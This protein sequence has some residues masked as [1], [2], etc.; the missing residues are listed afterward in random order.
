MGRGDAALVCLVLF[1]GGLS[2]PAVGQS[3]SDLTRE[4][5]REFLLTAEIISGRQSGEGLT[6]PWRLTLSDGTFTHDASYS[7]VD[8]RRSVMEF[9]DGSREVNFVDSYQYNIAAYDLTVVLGLDDMMPVTVERRWQDKHGALSWWVD[10]VVMDEARRL[11]KGMR[12]PDTEAWNQQMH[13]MRVFGQLVYDTDRNVGNVL[14]D[15][16]WRLWMI[17]F[18][19]AFRLWARIDRPQDLTRCDR[20]LLERLRTLTQAEVQEAVG[21]RVS[22]V[23]VKALMAR[24]QLIVEHFDRLVA[25]KGPAAVLY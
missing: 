8:E 1:L 24:R 25:Q 23:A 5:R 12:A 6:L 7:T 11:K 21:D 14:I 4:Q 2:T 20:Q 10:D 3:A 19:R 13:R 9:S 17:D 18:T 16:H 15:K 22:S